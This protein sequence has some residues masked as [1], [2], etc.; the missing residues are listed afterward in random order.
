MVQ[1][2]QR[3]RSGHAR[4]IRLSEAVKRKSAGQSRIPGIPSYAYAK[5][6]SIRCV[7]DS[8]L[9]DESC[10]RPSTLTLA[11]PVDSIG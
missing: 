1:G 8:H 2:R 7:T 6:R 5:A 10:I 11:E 4:K 3:T 9:S